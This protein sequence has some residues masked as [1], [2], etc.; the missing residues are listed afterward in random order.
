MVSVY[1]VFVAKTVCA[2]IICAAQ[3]VCAG[4]AEITSC[5]DVAKERVHSQAGHLGGFASATGFTSAPSGSANP[6]ANLP[7]RQ[8]FQCR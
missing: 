3:R 7:T 2:K 1:L 6:A 8:M 4:G 5:M